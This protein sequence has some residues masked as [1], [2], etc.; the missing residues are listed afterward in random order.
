MKTGNMSRTGSWLGIVFLAMGLFIPGLTA[1]AETGSAVYGPVTVDT[2][3]A[4][5]AIGPTIKASGVV[6]D[7]S[8]NYPDAMAI[9]IEMNADIYAGAEVDWWVLALAGSSWYYLN[10]SV[11]WKPFDGH[12]SNCHPLYQGALF[13][14]PATLLPEL[15]VPGLPVSSYT[16]WFA[17]D[18]PMDGIFSGQMLADSVNVTMLS[19]SPAPCIKA[20]GIAGEIT[21]YPPEALTI[22]VEMDARAYAGVP[23]DWWVIVCA[24]GTWLYMDSVTGW[25]E[26]DTWHPMLQC[27][28]F[29]LP[30]TPVLNIR[31]PIYLLP[32][33][34]KFYFVVDYPMD[35]ILNMDQIWADSVSVTVQ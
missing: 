9:T 31:Y 20:N 5:P 19:A 10:N 32:G 2:R 7:V 3:D 29:N 14:L 30:T 21:V 8:I 15:D 13:N 16:F 12:L 34:Y 11:Q 4:I 18:L 28:L 23:A 22:T 24:N 1:R 26:A 35:G 17:V 33:S 27:A 25:T 6:G